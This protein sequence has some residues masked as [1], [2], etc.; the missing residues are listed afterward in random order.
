MFSNA[1]DELVDQI[2]WN[3]PVFKLTHKC[4][5]DDIEHSLIQCLFDRLSG[6]SSLPEQ[7]RIGLGTNYFSLSA[8]SEV[9][10]QEVTYA[11][12]KVSTENL[13]DHLQIIA[14]LSLLKRIGISPSLFIDRDDEIAFCKELDE[15]QGTVAM[16]LNGWF[17]T[18]S[19]QWPPHKNISPL[20]LGFHIR[21]FQCP[22]LIS[23]AAIAHYKQH[24]PIGC[25]D[26]Y[27][28]EL[29]ESKGVRCFESN[30]LSLIYPRRILNEIEQ[31]KIIVASRDRRILDI[32]PNEMSDNTYICHYSGSFDFESN[33]NEADQILDVYQCQAKLVITTPAA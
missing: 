16:M 24:E 18:N 27:T 11:S 2:D 12:L 32:L 31:T 8:K 21:L 14:N 10:S 6:V 4:D 23:E 22:E 33:M 20:F 7:T 17:K 9:S 13:G 1:T 25:R 15:R 3:T 26:S 29:L 5:N 19:E 28:K 30:C